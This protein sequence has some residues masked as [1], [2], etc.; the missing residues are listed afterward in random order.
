MQSKE[1]PS[2]DELRAQLDAARRR[3][4]ELTEEVA[5]NDDKMRRTQQRELKLLHAEDLDSLLTVLVDGLRESYGLEYVSVVLCDPDHDIRHLLIA[6]GTPPE[7]IANLL[8]TE[9]LAGS[10]TAIRC[11]ASAMAGFIRRLRSPDDLPEC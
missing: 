7:N 8:M 5:R 1:E 4:D 3:L 11:P 10:G 2:V 6:N 9:S